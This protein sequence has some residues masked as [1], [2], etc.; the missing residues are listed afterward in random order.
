MYDGTDSYW[1]KIKCY[2]LKINEIYDERFWWSPLGL[3]WDSVFLGQVWLPWL[4]QDPTSLFSSGTV[5]ECGRHVTN[6]GGLPPRKR[7][8]R[9]ESSTWRRMITN[10]IP[11][12]GY[13]SSRNGRHGS[14]VFRCLHVMHSYGIWYDM[15]L[16]MPSSRLVKP[17][18]STWRRNRFIQLESPNKGH[19]LQM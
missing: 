18:P 5:R 2:V 16:R 9:G 1:C 6:D 3:Q 4:G 19:L 17:R 11:W 12:A 15:S 14:R 13:V 10:G 8:S 7:A